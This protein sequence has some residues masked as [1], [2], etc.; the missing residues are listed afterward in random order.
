MNNNQVKSTANSE[1]RQV[2]VSELTSTQAYQQ[3]RMYPATVNKII[4]N[5]DPKRIGVIQV[6]NRDGKYFIMDGKH[7]V[8]AIRELFGHDALVNCEIHDGMSYEDE[9]RYL[10]EQNENTRRVTPE[11]KIHALAEAKDADCVFITKTLMKHDIVLKNFAGDG[12]CA[13]SGSILRAYKSMSK[14][15]FEEF[16]GIL[17]ATWGGKYKSLDRRIIG[18]LKKFYNTYKKEFDRKRF[19]RV[20]GDTTPES[21]LRFGQSAVA[22]DQDGKYA[23]VMLNIYNHN[24]RQSA[25]RLEYKF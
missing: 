17:H 14:N 11:Q 20:V 1:F 2:K 3:G 10:A 23:S 16:V 18:G 21:I 15:E 13:C 6:S 9:A 25:N 24:L 8:V 22:A 12:C 7:R 5:Y 19:V 4:K